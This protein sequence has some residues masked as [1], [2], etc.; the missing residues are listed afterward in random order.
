[1][2]F[3]RRRAA[4]LLQALSSLLPR[5]RPAQQ[6]L[7]RPAPPEASPACFSR[8]VVSLRRSSHQ[9][10]S[11]LRLFRLCLLWPPNLQLL[12]QASSR[13]SSKP[14]RMRPALP[15]KPLPYLRRA[16]LLS[17]NKRAHPAPLRKCSRAPQP[18]LR[19]PIRHSQRSSRKRASQARSRRCSRN[20]HRL[21]LCSRQRARPHFRPHRRRMISGRALLHPRHR[22]HRRQD[23]V[24][25]LPS[26]FRR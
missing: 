15:R 2:R 22:C 12:A 5:R 18:Q 26:C 4:H 20:P 25:A 24:V 9:H 7:R 6:N 8:W 10:R 13:S 17:R 16:F 1:M 23:K 14:C 21:C 3:S 11:P 19:N